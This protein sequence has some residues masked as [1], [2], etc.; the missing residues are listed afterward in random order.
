MMACKYCDVKQP[1][2]NAA[3][4]VGKYPIGKPFFTNRDEYGIYAYAVISH[5]NGCPAFPDE[6]EWHLNYMNCGTGHYIPITFCPRCGEK[7]G[8]D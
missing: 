4:M 3:I 5:Q 7:L 2:K 1:R 8:D 6:N